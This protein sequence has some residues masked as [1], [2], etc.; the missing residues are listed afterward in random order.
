MTNKEIFRI[1]APVGAKWV[2]WVRPVPFIAINDELKTREFFDFSIPD[3]K[4]IDKMKRDT[5]IIVDM[6]NYESVM[7][8]L[9]LARKGYRP[10]PIYNGTDEQE[11]AKATVNNQ[12]IDIALVWGA[13]ELKK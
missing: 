10:I 9:A 1:W 2:D 5:A 3:I 6:P 7:H 11:G 8:G 12:T 4:Y 13:L